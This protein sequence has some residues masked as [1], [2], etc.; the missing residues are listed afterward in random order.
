ME[1]VGDAFFLYDLEGVLLDINQHACDSLG[2]TREELES[3]SMWDIEM[4]FGRADIS[5]ALGQMASGATITREGVHRRNDGTTFPVELRLALAIAK[6]RDR[7]QIMTLARDITERKSLQDRFIRAQKMASV[8]RLAGGVVHD[9]NNLLTAIMGYARVGE[10]A[11]SEDPGILRASLEEIQNAA[12]CASRLT[13]QLLAFSRP[14]VTER[15]ILNIND[16]VMKMDRMLR[17]LVGEGIELVTLPGPD[18]GFVN[19]DPGQMEQVLVNLAVNAS[20]AMPQGG[21]LVIETANV[22]VDREHSMQHPE[23]SPGKYVMLAVSDTGTG[24]TEEVK[25]HVF[26]PFFTTKEVDVGTGLGLSTCEAIV[27]LTGGHI[28]VDSAPDQGAAFKVF[29]PR[30]EGVVA[31]VP[32]RDDPEDAPRGSETV[33]L[34][35]DEPAVRGMITE[36]L[37]KQGYTVL[38]GANGHEALRVARERAHGEIHL[39]LTDVVMPLLGG[40]GLA[41]RLKVGQ[42]QVKVLYTSGYAEPALADQ[43]GLEFMQKPF[44]PQVLLRKVREVLD[45]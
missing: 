4:S 19:V 45:G 25:S 35:E 27:K 24:M 22:C 8:G 38:E 34:A 14:E 7:P 1:H 15:D 21:K 41:E 6:S 9:F 42:P 20:D 39:L 17:R 5:D 12:E 28:T 16:L 31:S 18:V 13:R 43:M 29:L 30:V 40:R 3:L 2:Y 33:L 26:E 23:L 36:V 10:S 32:V 11:I 44:T 37:R